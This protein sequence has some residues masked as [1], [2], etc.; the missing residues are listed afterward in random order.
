M[1]P[2]LPR[3]PGTP[4]PLGSRSAFKTIIYAVYDPTEFRIDWCMPLLLHTCCC[5]EKDS[6]D[7]LDSLHEWQAALFGD[8]RLASSS[9]GAPDGATYAASW[10]QGVQYVGPM[11]VNKVHFID[12]SISVRPRM[13]TAPHL[14]VIPVCAA[15]AD[16]GAERGGR[17]G[18]DPFLCRWGAGASPERRAAALA[19]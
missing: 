7:S 19:L 1:W 15:G 10:L 14:S 13:W 11:N 18:C 3:A 17:A 12:W 4:S 5:T 8:V 9:L 6:P 16:G 2:L